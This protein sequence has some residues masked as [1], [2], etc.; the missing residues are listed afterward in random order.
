[1]RGRPPKQ[2]LLMEH[3]DRLDLPKGHVEDGETEI[4]CALRELEE[5]TGITT[6]DIDLDRSFRFTTQYQVWKKKSQRFADKTTV[7]FLGYLKTDV[8]IRVTE[9][10]GFQWRDWGPPHQI[11]PETIDPLLIHLHS[12]LG[13]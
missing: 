3:A 1:M 8:T 11:Q 10:Q 7:I 4:E 6:H 12:F 5:E 13:G 9:H 2:F